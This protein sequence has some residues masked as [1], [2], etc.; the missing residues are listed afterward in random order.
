MNIGKGWNWFVGSDKSIIFW[1]VGS[2]ICLS[3]DS[4]LFCEA[5]SF[6]Q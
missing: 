2:S 1:F 5:Q 6:A 4:G 3:E